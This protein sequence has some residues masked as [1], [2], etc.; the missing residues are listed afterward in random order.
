MHF[1]LFFIHVSLIVDLNRNVSYAY[2]KGEGDKNMV[3]ISY[4]HSLFESAFFPFFFEPT[5][6][7]RCL[8][9]LCVLLNQHKTVIPKSIRNKYTKKATVKLVYK[10]T[11]PI[12]NFVNSIIKKNYETKS[13]EVG[14][15]IIFTETP[16]HKGYTFKA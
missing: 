14:I 4:I 13:G 2:Y 5:L 12:V 6:F 3:A 1:F 15:T 16:E 8:F 11:K 9:L 7:F 10:Q